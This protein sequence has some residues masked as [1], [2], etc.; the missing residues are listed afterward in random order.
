MNIELCIELYKK[1]T[2]KFYTEDEQQEMKQVITTLKEKFVENLGLFYDETKMSQEERV[3]YAKYEFFLFLIEALAVK[4]YKEG[5]SIEEILEGA[6]QF[7]ES[8]QSSQKI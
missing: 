7:V 3:A 4:K 6:T 5:V 8:L 2:A 1:W